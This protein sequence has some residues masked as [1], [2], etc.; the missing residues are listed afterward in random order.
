MWLAAVAA[1]PT[2]RFATGDARSIQCPKSGDDEGALSQYKASAS[3]VGTSSM[4][5]TVAKTPGAI[6]MSCTA[7]NA[8]KQKDHF[9]F[10]S[11]FVALPSPVR[12]GVIGSVLFASARKNPT[13]LLTAHTGRGQCEW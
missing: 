13:L 9:L 7:W 6:S 12:M 11:S 1:A 3:L 2:P 10:L 4:R 8:K 5:T